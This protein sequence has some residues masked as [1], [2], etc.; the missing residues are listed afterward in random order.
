LKVVMK[1]Q[2]QVRLVG[3]FGPMEYPRE[4]ECNLGSLTADAL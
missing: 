1:Y 4:V 2:V 3:E